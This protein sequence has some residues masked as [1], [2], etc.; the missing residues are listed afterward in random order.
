MST[1]PVRLTLAA[2][3][4]DLADAWETIAA[5]LP[6]V[7]VHRGSILDLHCDAYVSPANSYGFLDGG[8]DAVYRKHFGDSLQAAVR[9]RIAAKYHG[10][11]LVG[12][13]EAVPTG[14]TDVPWLIVAPTMRVPMRLVDSVNPYL[15]ARAVFLL[16]RERPSE[17]A[18]VA[19]PGLG[20]GVGGVPPEICARQV[21]RAWRDVRD[22]TPPP[23]SWPEAIVRHQRLYAD[24]ASDL[25]Y[26][27]DAPR[28]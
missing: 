27:A 8:I 10:E 5:K 24:G 13:A 16:Q 14:R 1:S 25:Q 21:G 11:I 6:D 22:G 19:M 15:A 4:P 18:H 3:E 2:L 20:T 7:S 9:D 23:E 28:P 12:Q 17:L 26:D